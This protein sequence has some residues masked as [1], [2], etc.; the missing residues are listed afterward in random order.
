MSKLTP[1]ATGVGGRQLRV[2]RVTTHRR[3]SRGRT[4]AV[5]TSRR[6]LIPY[7]EG[8]AIFRQY[9]FEEP[10]NGRTIRSSRTRCP[11]L[12]LPRHQVPDHDHEL[13]RRVGKETMASAEG[14]MRTEIKD[15]MSGNPDRREQR[16]GVH[17]MEPRD[18]AFET[19]NF[20]LDTPRRHQQLVQGP[21]GRDRGWLSAALS[22]G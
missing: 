6:L 1:Q 10:W 16:P 4:A 19:M 17:W 8:D 3:S 12:R 21:C 7:I 13:P 2:R 18:L 11:S 22:K 5:G 9:R 14:R 20:Q 15:G